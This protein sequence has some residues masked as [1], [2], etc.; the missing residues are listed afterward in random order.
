[1][2]FSPPWYSPSGWRGVVVPACSPPPPPPPCPPPVLWPDEA[3]CDVDAVLPPP[4]PQPT[5]VSVPTNTNV[6]RS[7]A[8][9]AVRCLAPSTIP[10]PGNGGPRSSSPHPAAPGQG[11]GQGQAAGEGEARAGQREDRL[12]EAGGRRAA[13]AH[14]A[15]RL[16]LVGEAALQGHAEAGHVAP[17]PGDAG[18]RGGEQGAERPLRPRDQEG[19][20]DRGGHRPRAVDVGE[21]RRLAAQAPVEGEDLAFGGE[22]GLLGELHV[23]GEAAFAD[24]R[25]AA[26][27]DRFLGRRGVDVAHPAA[28]QAAGFETPLAVERDRDLLQLRGP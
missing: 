2:L 6:A 28:G 14:V 17:V 15:A 3:P 24:Q 26:G 4:P 7:R 10:S 20:D 27:R 5:A 16:P 12:A 23:G 11:R 22:G 19:E 21:N 25:G 9:A 18:K 13:G 8:S 1:M